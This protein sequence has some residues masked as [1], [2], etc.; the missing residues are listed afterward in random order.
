[1]SQ[2]SRNILN[3]LTKDYLWIRALTHPQEG[4][5]ASKLTGAADTFNK[6][7]SGATGAFPLGSGEAKGGSSTKNGKTTQWG[8]VIDDLQQMSDKQMANATLYETMKCVFS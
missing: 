3:S 2:I 5:L 6:M 7:A 1:M 8:K 4:Q